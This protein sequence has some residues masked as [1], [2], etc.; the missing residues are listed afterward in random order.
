MDAVVAAGLDEALVATLERSGLLAVIGVD[1]VY[2]SE[3]QAIAAIYALL[4]PF[5][6][7]IGEEASPIQLWPHHFDLSMIWLPGTKIP[8]K[9]PDDE[10]QSDKQMSFGFV[11]GDAAIA[12]PYFYINAY[13]SPDALTDLDIPGPAMW[14][15]DAF[16]GVLLRYRDLVAMDTP[17]TYLKSLWTTL[18]RAGRPHLAT[19]E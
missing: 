15:T 3:T 2:R 5:R 13:P 16:T 17:E 6:A 7:G 18:L 8:G 14:H 12:E 4:E 10:E 9:D 11:F 1:H 19:G